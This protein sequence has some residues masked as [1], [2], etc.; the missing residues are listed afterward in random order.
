[1]QIV[2]VAAVGAG[3][4]GLVAVGLQ[5]PFE[6]FDDAVRDDRHVTDEAVG[7]PACEVAE[8]DPVRIGEREFDWQPTA[9]DY[10]AGPRGTDSRLEETSPRPTTSSSGR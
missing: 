3:W 9:G 8:A 7:F 2:G 5:E 10:Q 4:A 1:M 6:E